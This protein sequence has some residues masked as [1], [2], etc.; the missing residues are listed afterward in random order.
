MLKEA[1][2][3]PEFWLEA[4]RAVSFTWN[5]VYNSLVDDTPFSLLNGRK[6]Q[7]HFLRTFGTPA[8]VSVPEALRGPDG[9]KVQKMI[10]CGYEPE[11][12]A[13]R[14]AY[15]SGD[16]SKVLISKHAEFLEEEV[17][18]KTPVRRDVLSDCLSDPEDSCDEEEG[19]A[20]PADEDQVQDQGSESDDDDQSQE[21]DEVSV[22]SPQVVKRAPK[23]EPSSP[24]SVMERIRKRFKSEGESH[25]AED[26]PADQSE[27]EETPEF[28]PRRSSRPTKGVPPERYQATG[29]WISFAQCDSE[30]CEVVPQMPNRF[31]KGRRKALGKELI[32]QGTED[33]AQ[34]SRRDTRG[35][36]YSSEFIWLNSL[37][38]VTC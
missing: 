38:C 26:T 27:S 4:T 12:R 32:S 1:R 5:R 7:V 13:W 10:F 2:L 28:V 30:S 9:A 17:K 14:F 16:Q 29:A 18:S 19:E 24:V 37:V 23:S 15:P 21:Q 20:E 22:A 11:A 8:L 34:V 3:P 35:G 6:P 31:A 33:V 36:C 25:D